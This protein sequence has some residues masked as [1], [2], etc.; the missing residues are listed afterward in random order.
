MKI[1]S[2]CRSVGLLSLVILASWAQD[3]RARVQGSVTDSSQGAIAGA[4]VTLQNTNTGVE[5]SRTTNESG[6]YIFDFVDPGLYTV[7]VEATGFSKYVQQNVQVQVRGDVTVN[8]ALNVGSVAETVNVS[9]TVVGLQFNTSTMELTV[10]RKMLNELPIMQR[11][12]FTLAL[13]DPAVVNRYWD[14][15][16]RNPFYMWS[17]SQI[18]VGGNTSMKNDLLLDGAPIQI[19]VKGSYSPPMDAVQEFSVQQNS[20]DAEFGHSAGGIMSLGIKSGT[21]EFHGSAYYFGRN[22]AL[23]AQSNSVLHT[24][25]LVRNHIWGGSIGNPILKNR[26]FTFTAYE[27]WRSQEPNGTLRTMPTDLE[28]EGDFSQS[29]N[30]NGG[31]RTIYDPWT[32]QFDPATGAVTRTPFPGNRIP[33]NRIDPSAARFMQDIWKPNNPGDNITGANNFKIGYSWPQ[34][35]WNFTERVDW[36][37]TDNWKAFFRYS[38]VRT[39]LDQT[40]YVNSAAMP[41]D[42]GGLMNNRNVAGDTVITLNPTT[43]LNFRMSFASLEDDYN[44]PRSAIGEAGLAQ[45]WPNNPWYKPYIGEM[46]AIYYP[47]LIINTLESGTSGESYGK[48]SYWYQHPRHWAFEGSLRKVMGMHNLKLGF[49]HRRHR[50]DGIFPNLMNFYF[51]PDLTAE[52]FLSPNTR[53]NGSPW[54]TFLLGAID[55]SSIART[56]PFQY[57]GNNYTGAFIQ[58]DVKLNRNITLNVGLRYEYLGAPFDARNRLSRGPDLTSPIPEFQANPPQWPAEV[59]RLR[60]APPTLNGA[61]IF[62]DSSHP[63]VYEVTRFTFE[64]RIGVAIRINDKTAFRA[65][66]AR[67]VVPTELQQSTLDTTLPMWGY[68]AATNVSPLLSGVPGARLSD[69]FPATNPLVL[70]AGKSHGRYT[71]LGDNG[72]ATYGV[73]WYDQSQNPGVN[74]RWNFSIQRQ[75]PADIHVDATFFMNFGHNLAYDRPFNMANPQICYTAK[76]ACDQQVA[77]PFYQYLTPDVFPGALRNQKTVS[78]ASLL[79]PYPQYGILTQRGT[80]GVLNRYKAIQLRVQKAFSQGYSFLFAY[81]YNQERT[82]DFFNDPDKYANRL[83]YIDSY[84]PRHRISAAGSY[85]LPFGKGRRYLNNVH[86]VLNAIIGGWQ[87]SHLLL[88]NSGQFLRFGPMLTDGSNPSIDNPSRDRWFDTSKFAILPPYTPRTNPWQYPGVVGPKYWNLDSTLSKTFPIRERMNLEFRFEAY[89][90]TNSFV[91]SNPDM[92]VTSS[93][94]GRSTSQQ[95]RGREM[96][97]SLRLIF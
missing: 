91:P 69:P 2:I 6:Q 53:L 66:F 28:R 20:V 3:Y 67:Y 70:P 81:N 51:K 97:Y 60:T 29:R 36:N 76:S 15:A 43:V 75:L 11:N 59:V 45:F 87:T 57:F 21:N 44:A 47:N 40:Q 14:I 96:Q 42:N 65:G 68:S 31:L 93:T 61:W 84:W 48:G 63:G 26:L 4:K 78:V 50:A 37:I 17:S 82:Q 64:P 55:N 49:D 95:N 62:T 22:P 30:I 35:Y 71:N 38:R 85:D 18:D 10:D 7:T 19:G 89:N 5:T 88:L 73:Y 90:L 27:G 86:P 46:P 9:E 92:T 77:N 39:D 13:L 58:D 8:A 24:P 23:N 52:T 33:A 54:A 16:H 83:T 80:D 1:A 25:N 34:K 74:D 79:T 12:P 41:N 32:T 94:F 56:Y 72:V